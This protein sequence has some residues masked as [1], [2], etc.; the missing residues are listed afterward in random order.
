MDWRGSVE[1]RERDWHTKRLGSIL[2]GECF[3][4]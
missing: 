4:F 3:S 1:V 2:A